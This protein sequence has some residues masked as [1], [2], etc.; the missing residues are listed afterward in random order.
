MPGQSRID[1]SRALH[2]I[3]ARGNEKRRI[4]ED[5]KDYQEFFACLGDIFSH[6]QT[7]CYTW[8]LIPNRFHLFLRTEL[9]P[10]V[11]IMRRLLTGYVIY[12]NRRHRRYGHL[13]Q[14]R[15][16]SILCQEDPYFLEL[17]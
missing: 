1:A 14:N 3:I 12:F 10:I 7:P 4:F 8:A 17:V 6:L 9:I 13:L 15:Y 16:K 2:Y 5:K 11:T